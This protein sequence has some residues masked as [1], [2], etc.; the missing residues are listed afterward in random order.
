MEKKRKIIVISVIGLIIIIIIFF[1]FYKSKYKED[2]PSTGKTNY[3]I[4][5]CISSVTDNTT[6]YFNNISYNA[7]GDEST[8][9]PYKI[10][11][12]NNCTTYITYNITFKINEN[13]YDLNTLFYDIYDKDYK[14]DNRHALNTMQ[15]NILFSGELNSK[16]S[17]ILLLYIWSTSEINGQNIKG[18]ISVN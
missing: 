17:K 6:S 9:N 11:I 1:L 18:E 15:N 12:K 8:L 14:L 5:S 3:D 13:N 2:V 16:E 4:S 7:S 10:I